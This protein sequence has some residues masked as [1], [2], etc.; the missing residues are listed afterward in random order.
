MDVYEKTRQHLT[1]AYAKTP[2]VVDLFE[3][4]T[5]PLPGISDMD[6]HVIVRKDVSTS[7]PRMN[8]F[9]PDE[10][11][12]ML[13][14]QFVLTEEAF[15]NL[16]LVDPWLI[17]G[18]SLL[19]KV[20]TPQRT[21][22]EEEHH[23][24]SLYYILLN[25]LLP[26]LHVIGQ[27]EC[28]QELPVRETLEIIK[29]T[30]YPYREF[31]RM[32]VTHDAADPSAAFFT[33]LRTQWFTLNPE[34]QRRRIEEAFRRFSKSIGTL[35]MI[36]EGEL[37]KRMQTMETPSHT[38][39]RFHKKLLRRFPCSV[40][41]DTGDDIFI[42]QQDRTSIELFYE[43]FRSPLSSSKPERGIYLLPFHLCSIQNA[44]LLEDGPVSNWYKTCFA[45]D[46]PSIPM[47]RHPAIDHLIDVMN[48]NVSDTTMVHGAKQP[49]TTFGMPSPLPSSALRARLGSCYD[50]ILSFATRTP[51]G[52]LFR[53]KKLHMILP[54]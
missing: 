45:T 9:A 11:Y 3:F 22:S 33:E 53:D 8:D 1:D 27:I 19:G 48:K 25:W 52:R 15:A 26:Y 7:F 47:Y 43:I 40:I 42:Y 38:K 16:H 37:Q 5:I 32:G 20:T 10:R 44:H 18:T 54:S 4:G 51:L 23:E 14:K 31:N 46:L 50:T 30:A 39:S 24:L 17:K 13:H 49:F 41:L 6:F 29:G 36:A 12:A 28:N 34:E 2:N 21:L 35:L